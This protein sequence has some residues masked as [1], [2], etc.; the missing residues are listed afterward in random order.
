M[1]NVTDCIN[2]L[3]FNAV[4]NESPDNLAEKHRVFDEKERNEHHRKDADSERN[5]EGGDVFYQ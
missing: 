5:K 1:F 2:H 4:R 3:V